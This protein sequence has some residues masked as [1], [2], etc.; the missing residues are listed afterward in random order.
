MGWMTLL[1]RLCSASRYTRDAE[2]FSAASTWRLRG[3]RM[4]QSASVDALASQRTCCPS[5]T[6]P[7][8]TRASTMRRVLRRPSKWVRRLLSEHSVVAAAAWASAP[9]LTSLPVVLQGQ[10]VAA[11]PDLSAPMLL[12]FQCAQACTDIPEGASDGSAAVVGARYP[13]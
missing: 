5:T 2:A 13:R 1:R 4:S 12:E 10:P 3:R 9:R 6:R 11:T 7:F 8:A